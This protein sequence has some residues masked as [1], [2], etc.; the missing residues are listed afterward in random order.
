M[1]LIRITGADREV[2]EELAST[3]LNNGDIMFAHLVPLEGATILEAISPLSFPPVF[4]RHLT[5]LCR[6][7]ELVDPRAG[8]LRKLYFTLAQPGLSRSTARVT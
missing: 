3:S 4:K 2:S 7:K 6:K 1:C 5:R 8:G